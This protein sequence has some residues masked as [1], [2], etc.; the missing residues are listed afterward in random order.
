MHPGNHRNLPFTLHIYQK[1]PVLKCLGDDKVQP[2]SQDWLDEG[3][4][5]PER[6]FEVAVSVQEERRERPG[7]AP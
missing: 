5:S 7:R 2:Y 6:D 4:L 1:N 3:N